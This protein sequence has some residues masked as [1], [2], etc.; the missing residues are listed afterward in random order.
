MSEQRNRT[1]VERQA[2]SDLEDGRKR[3]E[4]AARDATETGKQ[5]LEAQGERAASGVDD[6]ADAVESAASRLSELEHQ[7]LADFANQ[8]ASSLSNMSNTLREKNVDDLAREV[9]NLARRN[10]AM[11][12]LGS[13]AVG[14]GLSRFAKAS[15]KRRSDD[16]HAGDGKWRGDSFSDTDDEWR[17]FSDSDFISDTAERERASADRQLTPDS[18]GGSGPGGS[19]L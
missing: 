12:L 6:F 3:L 16:A 9:K 10:P 13:V 14:L 15:S 5:K 8:L 11:F 19:G 2:S 18:T 1:E 4:E 17:G 7:G